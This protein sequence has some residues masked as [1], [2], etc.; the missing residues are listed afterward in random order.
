MSGEERPITRSGCLD[1]YR[2][3]AFATE[4]NLLTCQQIFKSHVMSSFTSNVLQPLDSG[5]HGLV[6]TY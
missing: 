3:E 2:L 1:R 4:L 5:I 6:M